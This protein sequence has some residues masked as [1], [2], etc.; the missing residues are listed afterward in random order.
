MSVLFLVSAA[1][2]GVLSVVAV[3]GETDE[4]DE[5]GVASF[6]FFGDWTAAAYTVDES[7]LTAEVLI[8]IF[9]D[10]MAYTLGE[11]GLTAEVSDCSK[12]G[13]NAVTAEAGW[14]LANVAAI[15]FADGTGVDTLTVLVLDV[16]V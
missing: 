7:G 16:T 10:L 12:F 8:F 15:A 5:S 1:E 11:C 2:L 4:V 13:A 6:L 9:G 14:F 3:T